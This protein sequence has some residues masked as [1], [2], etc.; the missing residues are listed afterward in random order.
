MHQECLV[1]PR[2]FVF[3]Y[4]KAEFCVAFRIRHPKKGVGERRILVVIIQSGLRY[5]STIL[6]AKP[7]GSQPTKPGTTVKKAYCICCESTR[8]SPR[9]TQ[10]LKNM[11]IIKYINSMTG[12]SSAVI[13]QQLVLRGKQSLNIDSHHG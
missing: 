3:L 5:I 4:L 13:P 1:F 2:V 12:P 8:C 10:K 7:N 6:E 9:R 11:Q